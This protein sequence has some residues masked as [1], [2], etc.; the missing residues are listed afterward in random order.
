MHSLVAIVIYRSI[1]QEAWSWEQI[2]F[3]DH[4]LK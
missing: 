4:H 2:H 1:L 3:V